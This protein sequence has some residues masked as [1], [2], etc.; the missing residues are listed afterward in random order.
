LTGDP[1]GLARAL[2]RIEKPSGLLERLLGLPGRDMNPSLLRSHPATED[3]IERLRSLG[4]EGR[5]L[6]PEAPFLY[7]P[8]V[9]RPPVR[10]WWGAWH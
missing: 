8:A 7:L 6:N 3:R 1:E 4:E 5:E 10:T 2:Q 9:Q